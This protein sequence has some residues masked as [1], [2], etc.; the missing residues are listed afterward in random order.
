MLSRLLHLLNR[1][2]GK[3]QIFRKFESS[4][5]KKSEL[6]GWWTRRS[7]FPSFKALISAADCS[8]IRI[9]DDWVTIAADLAKLT[10]ADRFT[11]AENSIAVKT[12][13][14]EYSM[15]SFNEREVDFFDPEISECPYGAYKILQK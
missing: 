5:V 4:S 14:K 2:I 6:R 12:R 8:G 7:Q 13:L 11:T 15:S 10:H 9:D 1:Q 3:L